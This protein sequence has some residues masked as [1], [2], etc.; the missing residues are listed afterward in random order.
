MKL[1]R[2]LVLGLL[3]AALAVSALTACG[4]SAPSA[5][6]EP[7]N[8]GTSQGGSTGETPENPG[9]TEQPGG[10][11]EEPD[12]T[13]DETPEQT[14]AQKTWE[15][16][17]AKAYFKAKG[18]SSTD[19]NF[20]AIPTIESIDA[21]GNCLY[22]EQEDCYEGVAVRGAERLYA[23]YFK[24]EPYVP[25]YGIYTDGWGYYQKHH[26]DSETT[27]WRAEETNAARIKEELDIM[28]IFFAVP[29]D[30]DILSFTTE[31]K[32]N[33]TLETVTTKKGAKAIYRFNTVGDLKEIVA[34][35]QFTNDSLA[36]TGIIRMTMSNPEIVTASG[37]KPF[38]TKIVNN[39]YTDVDKSDL[40]EKWEDSG[41]KAYLTKNGITEKQF[42]V[43]AV[44]YG[45]GSKLY[46][47][48]FSSGSKNI[49]IR[50]LENDLLEG[51]RYADGTYTAYEGTITDAS[52]RS[53]T[54]STE[55][56][57]AQK[58]FEEIEKYIRIPSEDEIV[59]FRAHSG[60]EEE[61]RLTDG[62]D[63]TVFLNSDGKPASVVIDRSNGDS[64]IVLVKEFKRTSTGTTAMFDMWTML[65][66]LF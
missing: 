4:S 64:V 51:Y 47:C 50:N 46:T 41:T 37:S 20:R 58:F 32:D 11:T 30:D 22:T 21:D 19:Y 10:D 56:A 59:V 2:K 7:S 36:G 62:T 28:S 23:R 9:D 29:A 34:E 63:I 38:P 16:S 18:V 49:R 1:S 33:E 40:P 12:K 26:L 25:N 44:T 55:I 6:S 24:D 35:A 39:P 27:E 15:N 43:K 57:T 31:T 53:L 61:I 13:P 66:N 52:E 65:L 3:A 45:A 17:R 60:V 14:P 42:Y 8:P 48:E 5:P 54:D